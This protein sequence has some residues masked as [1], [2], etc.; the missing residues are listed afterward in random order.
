MKINLLSSIIIMSISLS[1]KAQNTTFNNVSIGTDVPA[2]GVQIKANFP[3]VTAG[4]ARSFHITNEDGTQNFI[5]LGAFGG[6]ANGISSLKNA[7]IGKDWDSQYMTFLANGNI[8]INT[9]APNVKLSVNGN[10]IIT[11][12][13][14]AWEEGI[15]ID[16]PDGIWGGIK[17]RTIGRNGYNG[18]WH[19]GY[20]TVHSGATTTGNN[21]YL[22]NGSNN[23]YVMTYKEDG[24]VGIGTKNPDSKLTVAG[25]I[26]AQEVKVTV[27]AGADF[28]FKEDYDLPSLDSVEMFIKKNNHLPEIASAKEMKEN[29]INLSEMNIKLLQKIEEMTLYMIGFKKEIETLKQENKDLK[30]K[31]NKIKKI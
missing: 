20:D 15:N 12:T 4:W 27:N 9:T 19:F 5:G 10:T 29:G 1:I 30:H 16:S 14:G 22:Y 3:G 18:N 25:N 2:N 28:V 23:S 6:V 21:I 17:F 24:N 13:S 11:A 8:G 26:H 31:I 7:Y